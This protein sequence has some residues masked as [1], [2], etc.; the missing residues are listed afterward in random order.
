MLKGFGF[1]LSSRDIDGNLFKGNVWG[2]RNA[3]T[4]CVKCVF[5]S[6]DSQ[7]ELTVLH[8]VVAKKKFP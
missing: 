5:F 1:S 6:F 7:G 2:R 8:T 3:V 4:V